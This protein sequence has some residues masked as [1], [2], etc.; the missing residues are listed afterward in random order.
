MHES[1]E[2]KPAKRML[3]VILIK[4]II[5]ISLELNATEAKK[6][7]DRVLVLH[8]ANLTGLPASSH[9]ALGDK[10]Y[11]SGQISIGLKSKP[12][13]EEIIGEFKA[14]LAFLKEVTQIEDHC[15]KFLEAFTAVGGSYGTAAIALYEE[16][17]GIGLNIEL[18]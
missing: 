2:A 7:I 5:V 3:I 16:W 10:L 15:M 4:F 18:N 12:T 11:T 13:I 8:Y 17:T 6:S 1:T 14:S 9:S